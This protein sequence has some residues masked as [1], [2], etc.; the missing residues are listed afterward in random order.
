MLYKAQEAAKRTGIKVI[1]N[2][3]MN[4]FNYSKVIIIINEIKIDNP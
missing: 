4:F 3:I 1:I 2:L